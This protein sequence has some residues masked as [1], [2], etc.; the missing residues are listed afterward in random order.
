MLRRVHG[1]RS[2]GLL[3]GQRALAIGALNPL[4]FLGTHAHTH[5]RLTPFRRLTHSREDL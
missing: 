4:N 3:Y 1:E 2:V 5:S